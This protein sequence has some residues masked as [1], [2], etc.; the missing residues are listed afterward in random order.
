MPMLAPVA[1]RASTRALVTCVIVGLGSRRVV[2]V[3]VMWHPTDAR[4]AQ[5]LRDA[6]PFGAAPQFLTRDND[7]T[8]GARFARVATGSR[9]DWRAL[10]RVAAAFFGR[11]HTRT[12]GHLSCS[13]TAARP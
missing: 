7:G 6:T 2:H 11:P 13:S 9:I 3:D 5:Q 1:I 12:R 4:V 10:D 8:F